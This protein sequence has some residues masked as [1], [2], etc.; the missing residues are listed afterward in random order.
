MS[1][2]V[3]ASQF[4]YDRNSLSIQDKYIQLRYMWDNDDYDRNKTSIQDKY[5]SITVPV[6]QW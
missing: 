1:I 2:K 5:M 6:R 4:L 3:H